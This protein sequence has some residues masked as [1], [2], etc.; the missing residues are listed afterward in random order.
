MDMF[1]MKVNQNGK[2]IY[3]A[4]TGYHDDCIIA[5]LLALDCINKGVYVIR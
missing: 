4:A 3:N 1:E 2:H 5:M